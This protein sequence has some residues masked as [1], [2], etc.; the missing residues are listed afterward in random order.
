MAAYSPAPMRRLLALAALT[1]TTAA[2]PQAPAPGIVRVRLHTSAGPIIV[3]LESARAP[4]TTAN[5][6]QYVDDGRFDG[7]TFYRAARK[8][9]D[10]RYG[11]VQAGIRTDAR[12]ILRTSVPM[13]RTDVTGIRHLDATISMARGTDPDSAAG[14]FV[15]TVGGS[16]NL[17]AAGGYPG[18]AAFGRVIAGMDVVKRIL[19]LPT[20][21]GSGVMRGQMILKPVAL[22]RAE[23]LDGRARPS[24]RVKP[25]L[26]A[27][28]KVE[29]R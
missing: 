20:G 4:R 3:A 6:L 17:D 16:P 1:L 19:A 7:V 27:L 9:I 15:I 21:G 23:R 5:F 2:A 26:L 10:P 25:W 14:N 24:G 8:K 12:R 28:P 13:E 11:F 22:V 18:Y 29:A